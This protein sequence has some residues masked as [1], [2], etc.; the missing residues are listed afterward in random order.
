MNNSIIICFLLV[1]I[2]A[3]G[4]NA[5]WGLLG[6]PYGYGGYGGAY[7]GYG[8]GNGY[9]AGQSVGIAEGVAIDR[10]VYG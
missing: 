3:Y 10:A 6:Y 1:A 7:G 2:I 8:Y 4:A 9:A 5:T